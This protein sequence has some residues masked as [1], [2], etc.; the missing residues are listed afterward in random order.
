M[1][2]REEGENKKMIKGKEE[3]ED[4]VKDE[5]EGGGRSDGEQWQLLAIINL[6]WPPYASIL[7]D[8]DLLAA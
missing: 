7:N 4:R 5:G 8:D 2:I 1:K 6:Y 3:D